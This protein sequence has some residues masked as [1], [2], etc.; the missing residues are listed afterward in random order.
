[1]HPGQKRN[2]QVPSLLA[3]DAVLDASAGTNTGGP[4][5][6]GSVHTHTHSLALIIG[7]KLGMSQVIEVLR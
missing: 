3:R 7:M 2:C 6:I 4:D 5:P 1:M